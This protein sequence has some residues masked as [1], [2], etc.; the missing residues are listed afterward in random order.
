MQ[1]SEFRAPFSSRPFCDWSVHCP[2]RLSKS[3]AE[4]A[5]I[6]R[7]SYQLTGFLGTRKQIIFLINFLSKG[8]IELTQCTLPLSPLILS[9][10]WLYKAFCRKKTW[11]EIPHRGKQDGGQ[12]TQL[13]HKR[14]VR[15]ATRESSLESPAA[16]LSLLQEKSELCGTT[17]GRY[18]H[19][20]TRERNVVW[21]KKNSTLQF[22]E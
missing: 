9:F 15:N 13:T 22:V 14:V 3:C 12:T 8:Y 17:L 1:L 21:K 16:A 4:R 19:L 20:A 11:L 5:T 18:I 6:W 2:M 7:G 10:H